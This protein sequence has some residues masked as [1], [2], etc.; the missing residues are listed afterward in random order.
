MLLSIKVEF[1]RYAIRL[2]VLYVCC[3]IAIAAPTPVAL[4][5]WVNEAI[6]ATYTY[7][8]KDFL[9][10]QRVIA[11]Y[12][13]ATGWANYST[14][15]LKSGIPEAVK[16]NLYYVSAVATNPP[17]IKSIGSNKWQAI[18]PVLVSYKNPQYQQKQTLQIT[19]IFSAT[20]SDPNIRGLAIEA[21]ET[22]PLTPTYHCVPLTQ[23]LIKQNT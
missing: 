21:F 1:M 20:P 18:M 12:Y 16:K 14:A 22:T 19:I 7:D 23:D 8:Y 3:S 11:N 17:E 10:Q 5:I 13:T 4:S 15:F 2:I 6:V 9:S